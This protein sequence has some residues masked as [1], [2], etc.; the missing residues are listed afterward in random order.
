MYKHRRAKQ[1]QA[2]KAFQRLKSYEKQYEMVEILS[3]D[4]FSMLEMGRTQLESSGY[5]PGVSSFPND[6]ETK[7]A[8]ALVLENTALFGEIVLRLPDIAV[9][10][11]R[12]HRDWTL[13]YQWCLT[14]LHEDH[15]LIDKATLKLMDLVQQ[16]LNYTTRKPD[17]HNPYRV[18][19]KN[20]VKYSSQV[21]NNGTALKK[22]R[23]KFH[24]GPILSRV[25][26]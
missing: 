6:E 13:I 11:M 25:E 9:R 4:I 12:L 20:H 15:Y 2:V 19:S 18:I 5:I 17:Y 16:E 21:N 8:L 7:I 22:E 10:I 23:K 26:L 3:K 14:F 1:L 24:K